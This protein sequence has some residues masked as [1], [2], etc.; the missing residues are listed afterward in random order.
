MF[1]AHG[2]SMDPQGWR[3]RFTSSSIVWAPQA[4]QTWTGPFL[5]GSPYSRV[6]WKDIPKTGIPASERKLLC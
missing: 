6:K 1:L 4:Y 5:Q 2:F 3:D